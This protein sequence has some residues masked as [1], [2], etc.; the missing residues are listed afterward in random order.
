MRLST[1]LF[2]TLLSAAASLAQEI[3]PLDVKLGLWE[4]KLIT[5]FGG[6]PRAHAKMEAMTKSRAGGAAVATTNTCITR[7]SLNV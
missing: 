3:K 4:T 2:L 7:E 1:A 6:M 5:K